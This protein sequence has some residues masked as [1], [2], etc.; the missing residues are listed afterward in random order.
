M[1]QSLNNDISSSTK[2]V[3]YEKEEEIPVYVYKPRL[4]MNE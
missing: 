2:S 3:P 4:E 1:N